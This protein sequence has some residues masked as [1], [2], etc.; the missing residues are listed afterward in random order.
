MT[1]HTVRAFDEDLSVLTHKIH[2]MGGIVETMLVD[3]ID[4]L[5][6]RDVAKAL[7]V[8]KRDLELDML[9]QDI[10]ERAILLVAKRQPMAND[11]RTVMGTIR[12]AGDLERIGDLFKSIGKR[13]DAMDGAYLSGRTQSGI[14]HMADLV[15]EQIKTVLDGF[16]QNRPDLAKNVWM[17]DGEVDAL[18]NSLFREL[19][20]YMMED[21]RSITPSTHLLFIAKNIERAGDHATNIAETVYFIE[22]GETIAGPRPKADLTGALR[23]SDL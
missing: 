23:E 16:A 12:M 2:T 10:E 18:H 3:A 7:M 14:R 19:L 9:Q 1:N 13:V 20:T 6:R 21:P 11:L 4:A 15:H 5:L 8:V 17:R 22:T